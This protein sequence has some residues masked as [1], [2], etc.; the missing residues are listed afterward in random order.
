MYEAA[1]LVLY[2]SETWLNTLSEERRQRVFV[3][4]VLMKIFGP[5]RNEVTGEWKKT[6]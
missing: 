4:R 6:T 2:G 3:N 1:L 5:R